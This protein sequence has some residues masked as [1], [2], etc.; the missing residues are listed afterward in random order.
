[1]AMAAM[2]PTLAALVREQPQAALGT[3]GPD[4]PH[5]SMVLVV[6]DALDDRLP[7][8]GLLLHLSRLSPYT[9]YLAADP[10]AGLL[11]AQFDP[12]AA[13]PQALPRVSVQG[14]VTALARESAAYEQSKARYLARFPQAAQL[15][16]F[17]DFSLYQ[18]AHATS[19][20]MARHIA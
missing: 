3:I 7:L 6:P 8:A 11:L 19:A 10:R 5:T 20:A 14:Q 9:R 2:H 4:G 12:T 18:P 16:T 15:F 1:M 13:D 17:T